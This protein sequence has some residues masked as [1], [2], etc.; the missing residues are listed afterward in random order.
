VLATTFLHFSFSFLLMLQ[1]WFWCLIFVQLVIAIQYLF[2]I[3]KMVLSN[4]LNCLL[5]LHVLWEN[6]VLLSSGMEFVV[7]AACSFCCQ[8]EK[9]A[10]CDRV[11][12]LISM[13]S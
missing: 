13:L 1:H 6:A 11:N 5:F 9:N 3:I 2:H 4:N 10:G 7:F 12:Y 8:V